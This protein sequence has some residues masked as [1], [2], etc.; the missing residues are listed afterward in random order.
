MY[1]SPGEPTGDQFDGFTTTDARSSCFRVTEW[2]HGTGIR[3]PRTVVDCIFVDNLSFTFIHEGICRN[4]SASCRPCAVF[5]AQFVVGVSDS[6]N[7]TAQHTRI[8]TTAVTYELDEM[9][10][11]TICESCTRPSADT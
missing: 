8:N 1:A 5:D 7:F 10:E 3:I 11:R 9:I 2:G 4:M 6:S